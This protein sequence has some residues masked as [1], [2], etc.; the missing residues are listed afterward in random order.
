MLTDLERPKQEV[1]VDGGQQRPRQS[2]E[3]GCCFGCSCCNGHEVMQLSSVPGCEAVW[4][5][6]DDNDTCTVFSGVAAISVI[7]QS[8]NDT[9][10][11][12]TVRLPVCVLGVSAVSL[13]LD[14]KL[15]SLRGSKS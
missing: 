15:E 9:H 5:V 10:S 8:C 7:T 2:M 3:L 1:V 12:L 11:R 6:D 14:H 13:T 4:V